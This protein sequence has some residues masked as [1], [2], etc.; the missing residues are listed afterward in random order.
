[1]SLQNLQVL[2][3]SMHYDVFSNWLIYLPVLHMIGRSNMTEGLYD[4]T[5]YGMLLDVCV[6]PKDLKKIKDSTPA[7]NFN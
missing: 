1:M 5:T 4:M 2:K 3:P 6:S 7:S